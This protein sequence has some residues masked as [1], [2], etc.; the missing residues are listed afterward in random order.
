MS[1]ERRLRV[2]LTA[3][4]AT[5]LEHLRRA[6]ETEAEVIRRLIREREGERPVI[7]ALTRI[8]SRLARLEASSFQTGSAL[9]GAGSRSRAPAQQQPELGGALGW[10]TENDD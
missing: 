9:A 7:E 1:D 3:A 6:G 2:R 8:E 10:L 4:E 5:A